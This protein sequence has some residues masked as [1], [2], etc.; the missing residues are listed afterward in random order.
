MLVTMR[1]FFN[2]ANY[3]ILKKFNHILVSS[4]DNMRIKNSS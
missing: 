4:K 3:Q 1:F 2:V